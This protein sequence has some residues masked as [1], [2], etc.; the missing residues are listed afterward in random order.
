[1]LILWLPVAVAAPG[2]VGSAQCI[3]CHA[4]EGKAWR[5]SHHEL[6]MA[7]ASADKVLGNFNNA[8]FTAHGI[9]SHFYRKDGGY[10]VR[11]D[12]PDGKLHDYRIKYTF[13]WEPLQQYLI[14]FPNGHI[15]ALGIAWDSRPATAGGQRWFHL[16]PQERMDHRH[17]QHWTARSQTWNHQCAECHSTDLKKNYDLAADSY[18]TTWSEINVACEACHG[19]GARHVAWAA[20]PAAKRP[21]GDKGLAVSLAATGPAGWAFDQAG[22]KPRQIKP[23]ARSGQVEAC[24]RCHSRRGPVWPDDGGG[25]PLGNSHRLAL[26]DEQLYFADG[27]IK[28]EVFEYGSYAQSKMH[29][30]GVAC[31]NCHDPHS[32]KLRAEGNAL[33]AGCH[34]PGR[35]DTP[36]HHHHPAGSTGASCTSCH[37]PQRVY[38]VNDWRADHSLRVPRPDLSVRLGTPNACANCHAKQ[39]SEWAARAVAKWYPDSRLRGPHFAEAF[40]AAATGEADGAA[41]LL[42]VASD[43]SQSEIVRAS[44]ASRLAG[45]AVAPPQ[46][47]L[48]ALLSDQQPLVRAASLRFLEVADARTRFEQGWARLRDPERSVRLEAARVLA[49]LLRQ[50]LPAGE[51]EELLRGVAEYEASL[52]V[53]A[54]LPEAHV[55]Q[56]LLA[57]S[58]G[59]GERAE[60]AYRTALR[61]DPRFAPAYVNLADLYRLQQRDGEGEHLLR[62][63]IDK[64]T[65][66]AD[67]RHTLGLLLVRQ[68]R[69]G[70]AMPWLRQA[71]E[72]EAGNA[73]YSYVYALALQG[74]GDR[75]AALRVLRQAKVR[76]PGNRQVLLALATISRDQKE[77]AKARAYADE[78]L[79]RFP[80]DRQ[81]RALQEELRER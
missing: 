19:P 11:T 77:T 50:R 39:G 3:S 43:R 28:D 52:Q 37:M 70:E 21:P 31:S 14:E 58:I 16:Y 71:S 17:P 80:D 32:L 49:P 51:R 20:S 53:N 22:G 81:A 15:Q 60:Q 18:R 76:Q 62:D 2:Y 42:A 66:D 69:L 79:K 47:A 48:P 61:L 75:G 35:Y 9:T 30:A 27:Q 55:N 29:A 72:A 7:E 34:P 59:D 46:P 40:H 38:M 44:A 45:L 13:G 67:L 23:A 6:A 33:C 74:A 57:I 24:A 54:D 41:R 64:V 63:G 36:V 25:R 12:G 10:F 65:Y 68:K 73:H 5:G 56:G 8:R 26:L 78:L 4:A 1:L